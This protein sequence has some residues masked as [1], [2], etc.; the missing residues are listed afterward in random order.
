[1]GPC[2]PFWCFVTITFLQAWIVSLRPTPNVEDQASV[3]M[4]PADRVAQLYPQAPRVPI[5]VAFNDMHGLQWDY[6]LI[7][8][9]TLDSLRNY[10]YLFWEVY[11][12][13]TSTVD[14]MPNWLQSRWYLQLP[15]GFV[16][17]VTQPNI[18][19]FGGTNYVLFYLKTYS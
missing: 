18:P 12:I 14:K 13:H 9:S 4:T 19:W 7:P 2:L 15:L 5:L 16:E 6:S 17:L 11:I 3:F 10:C 8:A 1:M